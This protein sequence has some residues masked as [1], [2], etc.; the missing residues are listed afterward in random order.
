MRSWLVCHLERR[1]CEA[2]RGVD[3]PCADD[4]DIV[5]C[6]ETLFCAD[7]VCTES[8]GTNAYAAW[9]PSG[10][11]RVTGRRLDCRVF[12]GWALIAEEPQLRTLGTA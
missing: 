6:A 8:A 5:D 11:G 10:Q 9:G 12:L 4:R 1:V 7:R 2:Q 3:A